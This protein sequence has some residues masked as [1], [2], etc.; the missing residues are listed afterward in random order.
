M[1]TF[2]YNYPTHETLQGPVYN[3]FGNILPDFGFPDK[4]M[5]TI[6]NE[7][8]PGDKWDRGQVYD[9]Y[10]WYQTGVK[11]RIQPFNADSTYNPIYQWLKDNTS[12]PDEKVNHFMAV[13]KRGI[14]ENWIEPHYVGISLAPEHEGKKIAELLRDGFVWL[15]RSLDK[16]KWL[17]LAGTGLLA[18]WYI[19]PV[20]TK[21]YKKTR[22]L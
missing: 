11:A 12:F 19:L 18:A 20:A 15:P 22:K 16:M 4:R 10:K 3:F 9:L 14:D 5:N 8:W 21:V 2:N 6:L 7:I 1:T 17:L 13:F